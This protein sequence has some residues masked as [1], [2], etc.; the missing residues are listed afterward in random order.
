MYGG[1]G[2]LAGSYLVTA[3]PRQVRASGPL[4]FGVLPTQNGAFGF[5]AGRF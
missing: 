1:L 4:S 5:A 2:L 3:L